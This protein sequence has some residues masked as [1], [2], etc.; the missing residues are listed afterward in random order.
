MVGSAGRT[1]ARCG[2]G[3]VAIGVVVVLLGAPPGFGIASAGSGARPAAVAAAGAAAAG[4]HL[5]VTASAPFVDSG[6]PVTF[7]A[8]WTDNATGCAVVP[9]AYRWSTGANSSVPGTFANGTGSRTN[10]TAPTAVGGTATVEVRSVAAETCGNST[11]TVEAVATGST[12]E[13]PPLY[14]SPISVAPIPLRQDG[15]ANLTGWIAGG[16]PPYRIDIRWG[17]GSETV[18]ALAAPGAFAVEHIFPDTGVDTP[19]IVVADSSGRKANATAPEPVEVGDEPTLG[20]AADFPEAEVG[21]P[22]RFQGTVQNPPPYA[23][24]TYLAACN[25]TATARF[26]SLVL[27]CDPTVPGVL[28][29]QL[30]PVFPFDPIPLVQT[31]AEPVAPALT[32]SVAA[33]G[34]AELGVPTS[35]SVTIGG[36]VPPFRIAWSFGGTAESAP[37]AVAA[38]GSVELS[39]VP[40]ATGLTGIEARVT[41]ADGAVAWVPNGFVFV[42]PP[43][44]VEGGTSTVVEPP[45]ADIALRA[46]VQG[47]APPYDWAVTSSIPFVA[48]APA[49][50]PLL[51]AGP[52]TW[53][54]AFAAEGAGTVGL[55]VA[56]AAGAWATW[57]VPTAFLPPL[58]ASLAVDPGSGG[59][60]LT[61]NVSISGGAPPF[62]IWVNDSRNESA[63][64]TTSSDGSVAVS[65][66]S[67]VAPNASGP[68][69]VSV[70]VVDRY[71][72]RADGSVSA[73]LTANAAVPP[74]A[75]PV[76]ATAPDTAAIAPIALVAALA[77]GGFALAAVTRKRRRERPAAG[78]PPEEVLRTILAPSDGAERVTVELLAEEQGI[79]LE[80][81]RSTLDRLIAAG[82]VRAETTPEGEEVLAWAR[83]PAA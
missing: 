76:A 78:P 71:W 10:F 82:Q 22:V 31:L 16:A 36:G 79:P 40:N 63:A 4:P 68:I 42:Y 9:L 30:Q 34:P 38:D 1:Y 11:R 41:D 2:L 39:A 45:L 43:L 6:V 50:G 18:E 58:A 33:T 75:P 28:E 61:V 77:L 48:P 51:V 12:V 66:P 24:L 55:I 5:A 25:R 67:G 47:G 15:A 13:V 62:A 56:D 23:N 14:L 54:G 73:V 64:G 3:W 29:A 57:N 81:V 53:S 83:S 17:D 44:V 70:A 59:A 52:I 7:S 20:I 80:T 49:G 35:V 46:A 32:A 65:L 26:A 27:V 19:S 37:P 69:R 72:A 21:I 74:V 60:A 8:N